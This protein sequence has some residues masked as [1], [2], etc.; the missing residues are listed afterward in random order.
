MA[1]NGP[2]QGPLAT[3]R[4]APG[5]GCGL[6][7]TTERPVRTDCRTPGASCRHEHLHDRP[8]RRLQ[9][10]GVRGVRVR[11]PRRRPVRRRDAAG[12]LPG[13]L[14]DAGRGRA[15]AGRRRAVHG[16]VHRGRRGTADLAAVKAQ[17]AR[18]LSLDQD[19]SG[20]A[21][22]GRRDPVIGQLQEVAP[23]LLPPLFYS[24]YEAAVWS[25]IS[26]RRPAKQMAEVR[27]QLSEAHGADLSSW[28]AARLAAVPTPAQLLRGPGVP[29]LTAEKIDRLHGIARK[30]LTGDA[31]CRPTPAHRAGRD[32]R[33]HAAAQGDRPVLR[34]ADHHPGGGFTDVP[35]ADEPMLRDL[36]TQLYHLPEPCTREQF[37]EIAEAWRPYR[38][39]AAVLIRAASSRRSRTRPRPRRRG[40][41]RPADRTR[42][43]CP[44]RQTP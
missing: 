17:V 31:G 40:P 43:R 5:P 44:V 21:D 32:H 14:P 6:R 34:I 2:H 25:I 22:V 16:I 4:F 29:G 26:A 18:V 24:P 3:G 9:P 12:V 11:R 13:W 33:R 27:R 36:V 19:A 8:D 10:A 39:W 15:P 28:P 37:L 41:C 7:S 20:F 23:G 35:P 30:A 1:L 38:T 42:R